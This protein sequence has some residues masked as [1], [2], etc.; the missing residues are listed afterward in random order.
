MSY[1][2]TRDK[3]KSGDLLS[4]NHGD[5]TTF[6][7]IKTEIVHM[8]TRSTY[9]HVGMAL[10][11]GKRLMVLEAVKPCIRI[12]PLSMSGD[13]YWTNLPVSWN[14]QAEEYALS[15][16][17]YQ[18]SEWN[19]VKAYFSDLPDGDVSECAAYVRE[20][21]KRVNIDLGSRSTPDSVVL[22][23]QELGGATYYVVNN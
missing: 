9:S 23:A 20:I 18:Y 3:I 19:A 6:T 17:G 5:W 11:L 7:G 1:L 21:L 10:W 12:F 16:V 2:D 8:A 22:R 4:F 13:F 14:D 15:K